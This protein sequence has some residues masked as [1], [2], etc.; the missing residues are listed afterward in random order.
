M[1]TRCRIGVALPG[2]K[3][4]SIYCHWD[5]Y[6]DN[7]LPIL[8]DHYTTESQITGLMAL[9]SLS[10]L[11]EELGQKQ[12]FEHPTEGWCLAYG[13]D[14]GEDDVEKRTHQDITEYAEAARGCN[15][16]YYYLYD[17]GKWEVTST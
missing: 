2:G 14:R 1:S 3:I 13:R 5:G 16:E 9:G 4:E 7:I 6:P 11:G 17:D 12:D 15:A 10:I 8:E